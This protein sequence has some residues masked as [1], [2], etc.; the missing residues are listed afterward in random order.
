[1][2]S[3]SSNKRDL[4]GSQEDQVV[5]PPPLKRG[6]V[7]GRAPVVDEPP[8]GMAIGVTTIHPLQH[9][10][11]MAFKT[12]Q[13]LNGPWTTPPLVQSPDKTLLLLL[14]DLSPSMAVMQNGV[15]TA[16]A[17]VSMLDGL[18]DYLAKTLTPDQ[19]Q[20]TKLAIA[21]FSGT[22]GWANQD[23]RRHERVFGQL[24][25]GNWVAGAQ[26]EAIEAQTVSVNDLA[27]VTTYL[28]AWVDKVS[29]IFTFDE[30][31]HAVERGAGTNIEAALYF[32]HKVAQTYCGKHGGTA[33]VFLC[34]D[35][36]ATCGEVRSRMIRQTLDDV[37]FDDKSPSA[38]P[39]QIHSL[40]MG[41]APRPHSLTAIL[42]NRGLLG[43]AKDPASIAA[44]LDTILKPVFMSTKGSMDF[45]VFTGFHDVDTNALVSECTVT[46]YS[47]GEFG[48]GDNTTALFGALVPDKFRGV[49]GGCPT[50]DDAAKMMLRVTGFS[51]PNLLSDIVAIRKTVFT[52]QCIKM[53]LLARG[54]EVLVDTR[55][56]VVTSR[57]WAPKNLR[58]LEG[59]YM[60]MPSVDQTS[61][62]TAQAV[63]LLYSKTARDTTGLYHWVEQ[64]GRLL[65]DAQQALG[66]TTSS[67]DAAETSRRHAELASSSGHS[68]LSRRLEVV[69]RSSERHADLEDDDH[70][71]FGSAAHVAT[72]SLSQA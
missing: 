18:P 20:T 71:N 64:A 15:S 24:E 19:M 5:T 39:V 68:A 3:T 70:S 58:G 69:R 4:L 7:A 2:S 44:G 60:N 38:V 12:D 37:L 22:V 59:D 40:M 61:G 29:K 55:V 9:W 27:A 8:N 25:T 35:G 66:S 10:V 23:H 41:S 28:E 48:V 16:A 54:H 47:Q 50:E 31:G 34:T 65:Q 6:R 43:Y 42:G 49:G 51:S 14:L 13:E 21:A 52:N 36:V 11:P 17:I 63:D 1:M 33:Q 62:V 45:V 57:W 26:L 67:R 53:A 72:A 32:A 56:P 46:T 30:A